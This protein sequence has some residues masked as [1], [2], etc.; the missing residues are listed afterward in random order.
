MQY[1]KLFRFFYHID[2]ENMIKKK[3][4]LCMRV[5]DNLRKKHAHVPAVAENP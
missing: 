2:F 5:V 3:P 1:D 4:M